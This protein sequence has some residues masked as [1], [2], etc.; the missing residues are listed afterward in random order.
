VGYIIEPDAVGRIYTFKDFAMHDHHYAA[1]GVPDSARANI[2]FTFDKSAEISEVAMVQHT[3]GVTQIEGF[4]G[5]DETNL[6]S[7][8]LANTLFG[9]NLANRLL[10]FQDGYRDLFKFDKM[11]EGK[12]FR[13]VITKTSAS[14]GFAIYRMFPRNQEHKAFVAIDLR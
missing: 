2:T 10:M 4:V 8:G 12:V 5:D 6:R 1:A 11:G 9:A 13:V 3:N 7:I 14:N